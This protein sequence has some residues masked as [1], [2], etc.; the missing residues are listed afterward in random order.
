MRASSERPL[1]SRLVSTQHPERLRAT[2]GA[3]LR[4]LVDD[5]AVFPPGNAEVPD[6]VVAHRL[7]RRAWYGD[8][9]GPLLVRPAQVG[10]LLAATR[11]G[12]DL[13]VG[14]VADANAGLAGLMAGA[15][16]LLDQDDRARLVQAEVALPSGHDPAT[17]TRVLVD[18]LALSVP[19][20]VEVPRSGFEGALDVLAQD[21]AERAKYRTGGTTP[22]AVP[23]SDE[24]AVFLRAALDRRLSFKLTAGLH[25][26]VRGP[27]ADGSWQH[28]LLNVLAAVGAGADGA[29]AAAMAGMLDLTDAGPL[30]DVLAGVDVAAVRRSFVSFGCCGVT[31]PIDELVAE[32]L[33]GSDS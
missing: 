15:H 24:L 29:D 20:Y 2:V 28:G 22:N 32:G 9:V 12:D 19:T 10:E 6:A 8:L 13:D 11:P 14:V 33:L 7:H 17:A 31:D 3:L 23:E 27:V 1:P 25:H 21:G 5:A 30:L 4:D 16:E 18:Q 26:A